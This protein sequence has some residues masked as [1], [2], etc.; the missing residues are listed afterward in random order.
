MQGAWNSLG[1]VDVIASMR[2][3][4]TALDEFWI[5]LKLVKIIV[6]RPEC[7]DA[8][9]GYTVCIHNNEEYALSAR[10]ITPIPQDYVEVL[11]G[12]VVGP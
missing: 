7:D 6:S 2:G 10:G 8:L 5:M 1:R 11:L 4:L 3:P 9:Q 12:S